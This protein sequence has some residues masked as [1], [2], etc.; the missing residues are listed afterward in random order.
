M[1]NLIYVPVRMYPYVSASCNLTNK[2]KLI[3]MSIHWKYLHF[4][5]FS[6]M[7]LELKTLSIFGQRNLTKMSQNLDIKMPVCCW[8][9]LCW[10]AVWVMTG[11]RARPGC[12]SRDHIG[13]TGRCSWLP[14]ELRTGH[15]HNM[16]PVILTNT[17]CCT[18]SSYLF[19]RYLNV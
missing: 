4:S 14:L 11:N 8:C 19:D 2:L 9:P 1:I 15:T 5:M 12:V 17:Q 18:S 6:S 7:M 13:G 16:Q 10:A 3:F